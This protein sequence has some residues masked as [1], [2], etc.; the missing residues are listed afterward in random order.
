MNKN[1]LL[2]HINNGALVLTPNR[3][4][5]ATWQ[6]I[7][8]EMQTSDVWPTPRLQPLTSWLLE[9]YQ[10]LA[11]SGLD[12]PALLNEHQEAALWLAI[13]ADS[14]QAESLLNLKATAKSARDA[15]Q[16]CQL[17]GVDWHSELFRHHHDAES[18]AAWAE[19]FAERCATLNVI[20]HSQLASLITRHLAQCE[21]PETL[22]LAEFTELNPAYSGMF[23]SLP[24]SVSIIRYA[25]DEPAQS[26][27]RVACANVEVEIASMAAW[28]QQQH[29]HGKAHIACVVPELANLRPRL[30]RQ[31]MQ[32]FAGDQRQF[33]IS[34]GLAMSQYPVIHSA[35]TALSLRASLSPL[36]HYHHLLHSPFIGG[37]E[38]EMIAR[39]NA[40]AALYALSETH[41]SLQQVLR[42][43]QRE[44]SDHFCPLFVD[45]LTA[46]FTEKD[47]HELSPS[48]WAGYFSEKLAKLGWPGERELD[49]PEF[50]V[51]ERW[52]QS[53]HDF[54]SLD[55][56]HGAL[57]YQQALQLLK[58]IADNSLFQP[59]TPTAPVQVLGTL[60]AAG[61]YFDAIWVMGLDDN[62]W[63]SDPKP[64]PFIPLHLQREL[65]M[66]HANADRELLFAEQITQQ[67]LHNT[68]A[69]YFSYAEYDDDRECRP[70][71]FI[72]P[73][74]VTELAL[75]IA[76]TT[77]EVIYNSQQL[78]TFIDEQA[79]PVKNP[80]DIRGGSFIFKQQ[81]ACPFRAFAEFRLD[82]YALDEVHTGFNALERGLILHHALEHIWQTLK[83]Q[84]TLLHYSSEQL[85]AV[86]AEKT[87][88]AIDNIA[89][90]RPHSLRPALIN[91]EKQRVV[92][93][94]EQWLALEKQ[95]PA[96]TVVAQEEWLQT[97]IAGIPVNMRADRIDDC[98][99]GSRIVI[100][101][102]TGFTA[103]RDW[104]GERLS[105]P[106]LPLYAISESE[107][108]GLA[109]A[110]LRCDAIGFNGISADDCEIPGIRLFSK[111]KNDERAA[112]W[113][114]QLIEWRKT[115]NALGE[116]F[117][118]GDARVA[119]AHVNT[120][121]YCP[122][123]TFCRIHEQ[124]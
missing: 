38:S 101:Y 57:S 66:P 83:D 5:A 111:V 4:L 68:A 76:P 113:S 47:H 21:L 89:K 48:M 122:L 24:A 8:G 98:A 70:S 106:Q 118:Q 25:N 27:Q 56:V 59:Q 31:F 16:L 51:M 44:D 114:E 18:F 88:N 61:I 77:D 52:R 41:V 13:I 87:A 1:Q 15:W 92:M 58:H 64:N 103:I 36:A 7:Y 109:F 85:T 72:T 35:L 60:E 22:I 93:I 121:D 12:L 50:Q 75:A 81:A 54:A 30:Q 10:Q 62:T 84:A 33:N 65:Q 42:I 46:F 117:K 102:K 26:V 3:R 9:L 20:D 2:E 120:C 97:E 32:Q 90:H 29:Q 55:D 105:E 110:Q 112:T 49:S 107:I 100:D 79:P 123:T 39:A 86:I 63:P 74:P 17:W 6:R 96:F 91:L 28:A 104:F 23:A 116:Q 45:A 69:L 19:I 94:L 80:S 11:D 124:A 78:E 95:R 43:C 82:A 53:L 34:S 14:P 67:F 71:R 99:D 40:D 73:Y 115:L 108:D 37:A 119:P